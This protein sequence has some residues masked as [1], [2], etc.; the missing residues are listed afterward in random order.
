M[1]K[2]QCLMEMFGIMRANY[3]RK[4]SEITNMNLSHVI[5]LIISTGDIITQTPISLHD[6]D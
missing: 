2:Y 1:V 3:N 6:P 4:L 5:I